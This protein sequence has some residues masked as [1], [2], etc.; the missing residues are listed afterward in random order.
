[1]FFVLIRYDTLICYVLSIFHLFFTYLG[2]DRMDVDG[3]IDHVCVYVPLYVLVWISC[4]FSSS[5]YHLLF[6]QHIPSTYF[7][8]SLLSAC[9]SVIT[10]GYG[11]NSD[12]GD[13]GVL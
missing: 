3:W 4:I 11:C 9:W 6:D 12:G 1:M 7:F 2:C 10:A 8:A 5:I 13:D